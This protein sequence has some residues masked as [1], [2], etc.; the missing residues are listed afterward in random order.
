LGLPR[1]T[2]PYLE[3]HSSLLPSSVE[4][5]ASP[6]HK[7]AR[8]HWVGGART[9]FP[10]SFSTAQLP[11]VL[12]GA[13]AACPAPRATLLCFLERD[14]EHAQR[15]GERSTTPPRLPARERDPLTWGVGT[16]AWPPRA[17]GPARSDPTAPCSTSEEPAPPART[18]QGPGEEDTVASWLVHLVSRH[19]LL[20]PTGGD[21]CP[22]CDKASRRD[23]PP[24]LLLPEQEAESLPR[25]S[26]IV[27][28][29]PAAAADSGRALRGGR[30]RD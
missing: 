28:R 2:C 13:G 29:T 17:T 22:G 3:L 8:G 5:D 12:A 26:K 9:S 4:S 24:L 30:R 6:Q 14:S 25:F 16:A 11:S 19:R 7:A 10:R 21:S 1:L 18:H 23:P 27:G 15:R 20:Q